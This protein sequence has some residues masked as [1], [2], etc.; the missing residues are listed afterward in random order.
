MVAE[1][2]LGVVADLYIGSRNSGVG[3]LGVDGGRVMS[4]GGSRGRRSA[5]CITSI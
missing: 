4:S 5:E 2:S 3:V 1:D